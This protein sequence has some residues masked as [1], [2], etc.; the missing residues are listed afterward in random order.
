[1]KANVCAQQRVAMFAEVGGWW[2]VGGWAGGGSGRARGVAGP[3]RVGWVWNG[4][5]GMTAKKGAGQI[6]TWEIL[7]THNNWKAASR[8]CCV[9]PPHV[10]PH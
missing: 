4:N 8:A 7:V 1:M 5:T 2:W 9:Q 3:G 10:L 6:H